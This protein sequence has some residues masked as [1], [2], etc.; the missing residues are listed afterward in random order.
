MILVKSTRN[1]RLL[2]RKGEEY[3]K[4]STKMWHIGGDVWDSYDGAGT[5][6][7]A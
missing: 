2:A 5:L 3:K 7:V 6:Q 4:R 1:L